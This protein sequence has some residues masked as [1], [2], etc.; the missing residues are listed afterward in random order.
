MRL[1]NIFLFILIIFCLISSYKIFL[2]SKNISNDYH[3]SLLA[4][5]FLQGRLDLLTNSSNFPPGDVAFYKNKYFIYFGPLPGIILMPFVLLFG[6]NFPQNF[7]TILIS[8]LSFWLIIKIA[9]KF[10]FRIED[11]LWIALFY[12]FGTVYSFLTLVNIS[13]FQVQII[14]NFFI[15]LAI[16]EFF[17]KKRH[18]L[19][20]L[21]LSL[22]MATRLTLLMGVIFFILD[23]LEK[24]YSFKRKVFLLINLLFPIGLIGF[25]LMIYN[26]V[27]FDN[28]FESGY[29]YNITLPYTSNFNAVKK[30]GIF[31][32]YHLPINIYYFVFSAPILIRN[33]SG[34]PIFPFLK[35]DHWGLS[36]IFTSPLLVFSLFFL[37]FKKNWKEIITTFLIS[38]S[39][40]TYYGVGVSQFGYRFALDFYPFLFL[41]LLKTLNGKLIFIHKLLIIYSIIFNFL[42]M[43]S[44]WEKYPLLGIY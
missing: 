39:I 37:D 22:A 10:N 23:I 16:Y 44:I 5:S 15:L 9:Q 20:G 43:L 18:F 31:S 28:I 13:A 27:R 42:F 38:L 32:F 12:I 34:I 2:V 30:Y 33:S 14:G 24:N 6:S 7:L 29:K 40:F 26:F 21:Y 35:A 17:S 1:K 11:S 25:S 4:E 19:I 36:I 8:F 41:I 3:F